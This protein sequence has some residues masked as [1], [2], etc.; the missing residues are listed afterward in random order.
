MQQR[1]EQLDSDLLR[2][3]SENMSGGILGSYSEPGFPLY[4]IN[5]HMLRH[6]G[7]TYEEYLE[8]TKGLILNSI[9]AGDRKRVEKE[10]IQACE[11][12]KLYAVTYRML[13][14]MEI[15]SG[16]TKKA[17]ALRLRMDGKQR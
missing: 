4:F 1:R 11:K 5:D 6:L 10:I 15:S 9:Y 8:G 14:K 12:N 17:A 2:L 13:K 16:F 3:M 7:Y